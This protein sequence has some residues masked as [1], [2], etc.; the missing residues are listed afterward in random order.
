[1]YKPMRFWGTSA[2]G[3]IPVPF[4]KCP[5][6]ENARI[7]G[8]KEIRL[9]SAF[10]I[11]KK[12]MIDIGQDFV[13]QAIR[14]EDDLSDVEHFLIT[15][16]HGDHFNPAMFWLRS[17][18]AAQPPQN[19][20][21]VYLTD[22]A[23]DCV[24][25]FMVDEPTYHTNSEKY[26]ENRKVV[27]KKLEFYNT[28][29]I[30]NIE[31]TPLKGAHHTSNEKNSANFLIKLADGKMMY[32]ALDSG[33]YLGETFD[34]LKSIKLDILVGECTF[35]EVDS[36]DACPVHMDV[37]SCIK[38]LD[39]LYLNNTI[40]WKT[41]I[42]LSHIEAKGMNHEQLENFFDNLDRNYCVK[43]AYDGLSIYDKEDKGTVL[44]RV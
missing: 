25:K 36:S 2:G 10:R 26:Y 8:G 18:S 9:R 7:K 31:V 16:T 34:Y 14:L 11:D 27:F 22:D 33:Y 37:T 24:E 35:P 13:A 41:Q 30:N 6:C 19:I 32:Y 28:Y 4:C 44:Y 5:V 43:I 38:T 29:K 17:V 3:S 21:N 23:F 1:M 20:I 42:Y 39:M 40:D 15:H 12:I